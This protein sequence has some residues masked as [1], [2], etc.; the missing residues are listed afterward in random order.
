ML[1]TKD[2]IISVSSHI[3]ALFTNV[4]NVNDP[5][6]LECS[7]KVA[8]LIIKFAEKYMQMDKKDQGIL[9]SRLEIGNWL[10][11]DSHEGEWYGDN[12]DSLKTPEVVEVTKAAFTLGFE[13]LHNLCAYC[14]A[15]RIEKCGTELKSIREEFG[16]PSESLLDIGNMPIDSIW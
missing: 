16:L 2:S 12:L 7:T 3:S 4:K 6:S 8:N 11:N 5:I 1:Q 10:E 14:I 13:A 9:L 15:R